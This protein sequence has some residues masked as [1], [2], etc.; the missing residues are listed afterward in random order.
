MGLAGADLAI[1]RDPVKLV[2]ALSSGAER[3]VSW[4][5]ALYVASVG[6]VLGALWDA[7]RRGLDPVL[8]GRRRRLAAARPRGER[9]GGIGNEGEVAGAIASALREMIAESPDSRNAELDAFLGECDAQSFA[10]AGSARV[11]DEAFLSRARE[12][13]QAIEKGAS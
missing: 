8:A 4:W 7:R 11:V 2:A 9:A 10:P 3:R 5:V 12:L 13:A 6:V 1:E